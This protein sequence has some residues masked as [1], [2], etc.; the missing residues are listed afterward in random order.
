MN[1]EAWV[2]PEHMK[3]SINWSP[4]TGCMADVCVKDYQDETQ[5]QLVCVRGSGT[6]LCEL[7]IQNSDIRQVHVLHVPPTHFQP[8][9]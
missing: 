8:Y 7:V 2:E 5:R 6:D 9:F 3:V 1:Q 4:L